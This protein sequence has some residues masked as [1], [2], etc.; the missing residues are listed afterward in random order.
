MNFINMKI[1]AISFFAAVLFGGLLFLGNSAHAQYLSPFENPDLTITKIVRQPES[2][3]IQQEFTAEVYVKNTGPASVDLT[4]SHISLVFGTDLAVVKSCGT[5]NCFDLDNVYYGYY[6]ID[7]Q[8]S[9]LLPNE[10][11]MFQFSSAV[12]SG[13]L[14]PVKSGAH[15]LYA[16]VDINNK[17]IEA[18]EANNDFTASFDVVNKISP[19]ENPDLIITQ[20]EA[21]RTERVCPRILSQ[22]QDNFIPGDGCRASEEILWD[23]TVKNQGGAPAKF[24][25]TS[26]PVIYVYLYSDAATGAAGPVAMVLVATGSAGDDIFGQPGAEIA[27]RELRRYLFKT[28]A[29]KIGLLTSAGKKKLTVEVDPT[30]KVAEVSEYNNSY[31]YIFG[32]NS[33][34][35]P[36]PPTVVDPIR[37]I[38]DTA[39]L[40]RENKLDQ[41]L[42][43]LNELRSTVKEQEVEIK[44]L[45]GLTSGLRG[46]A[47]K[48]QDRINGFIAY[49]VDDNTK[50]LGAGERAAVMYSYKEA[51]SKLPGTEG[52][53]ADAIK[54]A[55]GRWPSAR[56]EPAEADAKAQFKR[57]YKRDANMDNPNDNAAVTVMAYGLRQRAENRKLESEKNGIKIFKGIYGHIPSTTEEWN[58]MQAITYSG[59][60]R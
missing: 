58:I 33:I 1:I 32:T 57:I 2:N 3:Y 34:E 5:V 19:F 46:L 17:I 24:G 27:A 28:P 39:R 25:S 6:D 11:K 45:R 8:I 51:F 44:Y 18:N 36:P 54:I 52:E 10:E 9:S 4:G 7:K 16:S 47:Q 26:V 56:S 53:L 48:V 42:T 59:A 23:V 40:L 14:K 21:R 60:K 49:G 55:N 43:E 41:I 22:S 37:K 12:F 13:Q 38:E 50:K 31:S 20:A 30:A 29:D 15:Y 35:A